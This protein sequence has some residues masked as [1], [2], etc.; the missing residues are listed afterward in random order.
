MLSPISSL[1]KCIIM[2]PSLK[3]NG[4][5]TYTHPQDSRASHRGV[6]GYI[7]GR[8]QRVGINNPIFYAIIDLTVP[9]WFGI[10]I[11]SSFNSH[12]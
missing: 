12:K 9:L 7:T 8:E 6:E 4:L 10:W 1:P 2:W 11:V 3:P 5:G